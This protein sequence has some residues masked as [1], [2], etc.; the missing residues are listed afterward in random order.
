MAARIAR[1]LANMAEQHVPPGLTLQHSQPLAT[2]VQ[3]RSGT[4][5]WPNAPNAHNPRDALPPVLVASNTSC[6]SGE[7][8]NW[9]IAKNFNRTIAAR[10]RTICSRILALDE[11]IDLSWREI[12]KLMVRLSLIHI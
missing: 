12:M 8:V 3:H 2:T 9:S 11:M 1:R 4:W 6:N 5:H 7:N 10:W